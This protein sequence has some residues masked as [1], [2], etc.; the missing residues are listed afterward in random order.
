MDIPT[1][2]GNPLALQRKGQ[3]L[4]DWKLQIFPLLSR[5]L[6]ELGAAIGWPILLK[7]LAQHPILQGTLT[8]PATCI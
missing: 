5:T 4:S 8:R 2:F 6:G 1:C 7:A 3:L